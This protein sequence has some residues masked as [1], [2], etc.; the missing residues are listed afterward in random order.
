MPEVLLTGVSMR[1]AAQSAVK[2][3]YH[4]LTIDG[5]DDLD[6]PPAKK[7]MAKSELGGRFD[8]RAAGKTT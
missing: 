8:A 4:P 1:A 3:G 2:A 7:K 6:L 5:F